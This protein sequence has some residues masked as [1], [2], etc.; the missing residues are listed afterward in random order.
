VDCLTL[1]D[2]A[3]KLS[4]N[5]RNKLKINAP[6]HLGSRLKP[7]IQFVFTHPEKR[8]D[9]DRRNFHSSHVSQ[10]T[11]V[12]CFDDNGDDTAFFR[13]AVE[14]HS[15]SFCVRAT[16]LYSTMYSRFTSAIIFFLVCSVSNKRG[17]RLRR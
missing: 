9:T 7:R 6:Y 15:C 16:A 10:H 11:K 4:R 2:G 1:E 12:S 13:L 3:D 8:P 17:A 5:V 14:A